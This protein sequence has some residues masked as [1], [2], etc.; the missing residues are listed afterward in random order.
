MTSTDARLLNILE[1]H[2]QK[3]LESF[4]PHKAEENKRKRAA[5]DTAEA[6]DPSKL[7]KFETDRSS[8]D[9]YSDSA[10]EWT[11]FGSDA[12]IED[13]YE[14]DSSTEEGMPLEGVLARLQVDSDS[15]LMLN[16]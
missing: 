4:K 15:S 12:Q 7:V 10:E 9:D 2:G 1:T 5:T 11:G 14:I 16:G 13:E 3:F 6:H 8:S